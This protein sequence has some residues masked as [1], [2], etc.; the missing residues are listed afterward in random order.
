MKGAEA[1]IGNSGH[2]NVYYE[3]FAAKD[4]LPTTLNGLSKK[5]QDDLRMLSLKDYTLSAEIHKRFFLGKSVEIYVNSMLG[6]E[7]EKLES[8]KSIYMEIY[9]YL[10]YYRNNDLLYSIEMI[11]NA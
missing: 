7:E 5:M 3:V 8:L 2:I 4:H 10:R 1:N 9:K 11:I 6:S